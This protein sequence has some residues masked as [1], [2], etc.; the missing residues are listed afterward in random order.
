MMK[1]WNIKKAFG[2]NRGNVNEVWDFPNNVSI[3]LTNYDKQT[4]VLEDVD[5]VNW[6]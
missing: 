1:S 2:E 5:R 4:I 3:L 6:V